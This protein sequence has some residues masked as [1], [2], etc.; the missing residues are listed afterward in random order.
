MV[1][2]GRIFPKF[3]VRIKVTAVLYFT[4]IGELSNMAPGQIDRL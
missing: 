3:M 4:G 2:D 1:H